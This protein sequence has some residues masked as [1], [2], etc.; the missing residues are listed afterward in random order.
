M[1]QIVLGDSVESRATFTDSA[2][3][4]VDPD[5]TKFSVVNPAGART[6]YE[7]GVDVELVK[8]DVGRYL[9][10]IL[11]DQAGY[12]RVRWEGSGT[13][14]AAEETSITVRPSLLT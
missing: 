9:V 10:Y 12:W 8:E 6:D 14:A 4:F 11:L 1:P 13:L 5:T 2:D 7:F 3:V